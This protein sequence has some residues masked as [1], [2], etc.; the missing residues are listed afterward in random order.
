MSPGKGH[1]LHLEKSTVM[2]NLE[3]S[4]QLPF[5]ASGLV[6]NTKVWLANTVDFKTK[7]LSDYFGFLA[8]FGTTDPTLLYLFFNF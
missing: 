6:T 1:N 5:E 8:A 7:D 3:T 4:G 2:I